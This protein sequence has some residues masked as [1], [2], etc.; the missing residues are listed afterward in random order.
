MAKEL[1]RRVKAAPDFIDDEFEHSEEDRMPSYGGKDMGGGDGPPMEAEPYSAQVLRRLHE[2][3]TTLL[4][5]YDQM[6][7]PLEHDEIKKHL[8]DVCKQ[9][10]QMIE[11]HE[12]HWEKHHPD[13]PKLPGMEDGGKGLDD[14]EGLEEGEDRL[15]SDLEDDGLEGDP[16]EADS[17]P[18]ERATVDEAEE[19]SGKDAKPR[20]EKEEKKESKK[21]DK[22]DKDK[23]KKKDKEKKE[24]AFREKRFK[25]AIVWGKKYL[26]GMNVKQMARDIAFGTASDLVLG[27]YKKWLDTQKAKGICPECGKDPCV[28]GKKDFEE[29]RGEDDTEEV[30]EGDKLAPH[31]KEKLKE[32][33]DFLSEIMESHD[34]TDDHRMKAFHFHKALAP[35]GSTKESGGKDYGFEDGHEPG[36][37]ADHQEGK[38]DGDFPEVDK[39]EGA[40]EVHEDG[41]GPRMREAIAAASDF[42]LTISK[43]RA[44]GEP[45]R[46]QARTHHEALKPFVE[47]DALDEHSEVNEPSS[48]KQD[49]DAIGASG[50]KSLANCAAD[51]LQ[52]KAS[53]NGVKAT[54]DKL[55]SM[56]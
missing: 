56:L 50:E 53:I 21:E 3:A 55:L 39:Q 29:M 4:D 16:M 10:V 26:S 41:K 8:A 44:Y 54:M 31:E 1:R 15:D 5:E 52:Q 38:K 30:T 27:S 49:M 35:M 13:L 17:A 24:K 48:N 33:H 2:D 6:G 9:L 51:V 46:Q 28:C 20:R 32:A 47:M 45:H 37:E 18:P 14:E 19:G 40:A 12:G 42:L 34:F 22:E 7:G 36:V 43:E 23:D 11:K 25:A